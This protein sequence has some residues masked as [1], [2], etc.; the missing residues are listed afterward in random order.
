MFPITQHIFAAKSKLLAV[1]LLRF[2]SY[3]T[4]KSSHR[5]TSFTCLSARNQQSS[6]PPQQKSQIPTPSDFPTKTSFTQTPPIRSNR[7][8]HNHHQKLDRS[9][10][11]EHRLRPLSH[12]PFTLFTPTLTFIPSND[13]HTQSL[14]QTYKNC[15]WT[16]TA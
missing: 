10:R 15:V 9:S 12:H 8:E 3:T 6:A 16:I 1:S 5:V 13:V 4:F 7:A 14:I 11:T 2:F